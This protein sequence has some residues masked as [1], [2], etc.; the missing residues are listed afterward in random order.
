[1]AER[2]VSPGLPRA[3]EALLGRDKPWRRRAGLAEGTEG[4]TV[5]PALASREAVS[6]TICWDVE[7]SARPPAGTGGLAV[8]YLS[9]SSIRGVAV[10]TEKPETGRATLNA[11]PRTVPSPPAFRGLGGRGGR[12]LSRADSGGEPA[13]LN[14]SI[15]F[16]Y[17]F[18]HSH[19]PLAGVGFQFSL[20]EESDVPVRT[21]GPHT[22]LRS[23]FSPQACLISATCFPVFYMQPPK[24]LPQGECISTPKR[25]CSW[26]IRAVPAFWHDRA[27]CD[28]PFHKS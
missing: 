26:Q 22:A 21:A 5:P 28:E 15:F 13:F 8:T 27:D 25:L 12:A 4:G 10:F 1:M 16:P 24:S 7:G 17:T 19:C 18:V 6:S 2:G 9:C 3:G 14:I 11:S 23:D 20:K